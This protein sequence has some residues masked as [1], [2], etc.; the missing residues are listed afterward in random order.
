MPRNWL[1]L[2]ALLPAACGDPAVRCGK[3]IND[4]KA[5]LVGVVGA[6]HKASTDP[7][8]QAHTHLDIA[9]TALATGNI[10]V[11]RENVKE[12]RRIIEASR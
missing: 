2:L 1:L 5:R 7:L 11:C 6:A 8:V 9:Q 3:D 10:G 12:A 4:M